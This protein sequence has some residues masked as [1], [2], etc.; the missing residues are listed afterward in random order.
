METPSLVS[1]NCKLPKDEVVISNLPPYLGPLKKDGNKNLSYDYYNLLE[2][3]DI[4]VTNSVTS[5]KMANMK[6]GHYYKAP[7]YETKYIDV[8]SPSVSTKTTETGPLV[9]NIKWI[10]MTHYQIATL[11]NNRWNELFGMDLLFFDLVKRQYTLTLYPGLELYLC[12]LVIWSILGMEKSLK[13]KIHKYNILT[14]EESEKF[15]GTLRHNIFGISNRNS[16]SI[17]EITGHRVNNRPILTN[18]PAVHRKLETDSDV[19]RSTRFFGIVKF[20]HDFD[21]YDQLYNA[22]FPLQLI[23]LN[24]FFMDNVVNSLI[25]YSGRILEFSKDTDDDDDDDDDDS[26]DDDDD[27]DEYPT[28]QEIFKNSLDIVAEEKQFMIFKLDKAYSETEVVVFIIFNPILEKYLG[29]TY[30]EVD[31][32]VNINTL[33]HSTL[34]LNNVFQY[35]L[36]LV[37]ISSDII[38]EFGES[39]IENETKSIIAI[40]YSENSF[41]TTQSLIKIRPST[42]N[43]LL[44]KIVDKNFQPVSE[45]MFIN[46]VFRFKREFIDGQYELDFQEWT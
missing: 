45:E 29:R 33:K 36:Y 20:A 23:P 3:Q 14:R 38:N 1:V 24:S 9:T 7:Y 17:M 4:K 12:H 41:T 46:L 25:D 6:I 19:T 15:P 22:T 16:S 40:I 28:V 32:S 13:K 11:I 44:F 27:A 43:K 35:P 2:L 34:L 42:F 26:D 10:D 18:F 31:N 21:F 8:H 39:I 5:S 30:I 37:L